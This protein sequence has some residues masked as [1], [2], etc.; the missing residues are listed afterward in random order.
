MSK[1]TTETR[2]TIARLY[3]QV[4]DVID[5]AVKRDPLQFAALNDYARER[6][7]RDK[8]A[9]LLADEARAEREHRRFCASLNQPFALTV[10]DAAR[11]ILLSNIEHGAHQATPPLGLT[12]GQN[13]DAR[14][15]LTLR[16]TAAEAM[17]IGFLLANELSPELRAELRALDYAKLVEV[18][19]KGA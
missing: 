16:A 14:W 13:P 10:R 1:T 8:F 15:F 5:A 4:R 18:N 19:R 9:R 12:P 11:V 6:Y 3:E 2:A 7:A 17:T